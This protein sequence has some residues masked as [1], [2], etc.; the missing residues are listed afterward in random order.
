ME[1]GLVV[2]GIIVVLLSLHQLSRARSTLMESL[3]LIGDVQKELDKLSVSVNNLSQ[4][5][6]RLARKEEARAQRDRI[7]EARD[8]GW[9]G[10]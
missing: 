9:K 7:S 6:Q 1:V 10:V 2:V 3:R 8:G 4:V 5:E